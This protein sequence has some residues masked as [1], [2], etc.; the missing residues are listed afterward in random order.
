MDMRVGALLGLAWTFSGCGDAGAPADLR[1]RVEYP[2]AYATRPVVGASVTIDR[3]GVVRVAVTDASGEARFEG[4][5]SPGWRVR[6]ERALAPTE[7]G[8][9]TGHARAVGL[10]GE[11]VSSDAVSLTLTLAGP[12]LGGLVI[13]ELYYSGSPGVGGNHYFSDQ[14]VELYN[15]STETLYADGLCIADAHGAAG[16]INPGTTPTRFASDGDH[17]YVESVWQVPGG[18]Q[19]HPIPPGGSVVIAHD[20]A[21]HQPD[22]PLDL[23][24]A[25]WETYN[26]RPDGRDVDSPTVA[27][28]RRV[29]FNGGFDWL[30]PVFGGSV[31]VF[32][33]DDP[34]ALERV[35]VPGLPG[36]RARVPAAAVID[37]V[38]A[39]MDGESG[40]FKRVPASLD[41]GFTHV[42]GTYSGESVRRRT[43]AM[44]AGRV[45]VQDTDDSGEDFEV[46]SPPSPGRAS[47]AAG[48]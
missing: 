18:G 4:A 31:V 44:V 28:L 39:L 10:A 19:E 7:A 37:A 25:D 46:A 9:L 2:V 35:S 13:R 26:D 23:S 3:G 15:N 6:A 43:V 42:S 1:V 30:L 38:D 36:R 12:A 22:S 24:D 45:V 33:V 5:A 11:G 8:V 20:G 17:V 47:P 40:R 16:E 48:Q 32:R 29:I 41:R 27:N 14:F 34:D 21:P